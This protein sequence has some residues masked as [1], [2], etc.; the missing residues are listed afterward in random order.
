MRFVG[1]WLGFL[2]RLRWGTYSAP[3]SPRPPSWILEG[4]FAA[5][6]GTDGRER[7]GEGRGQG[8]RKSGKW[9]VGRKVR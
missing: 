1:W 8:G 9:E 2:P 3:Q 5:G 7:V 4:H 6:K